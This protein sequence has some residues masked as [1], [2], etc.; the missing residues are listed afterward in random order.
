MPEKRPR[1]SDA[2]GQTVLKR[3]K[4]EDEEEEEDAME[5]EMERAGLEPSDEVAKLQFL[6]M[7]N[8]CRTVIY[9]SKC[10][11]IWRH[12]VVNVITW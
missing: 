11:Y 7:I 4:Q 9:M 5:M 6:F 12:L 1:L 8:K 2:D 3:L 10:K